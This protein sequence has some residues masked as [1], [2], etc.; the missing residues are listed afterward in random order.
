MSACPP[1]RKQAMAGVEPLSISQV[2]KLNMGRDL[3][4]CTNTVGQYSPALSVRNCE[5][6]QG[7]YS[8]D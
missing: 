8:Y 1:Y 5:L 3:A 4:R 2:K 6:T 7:G